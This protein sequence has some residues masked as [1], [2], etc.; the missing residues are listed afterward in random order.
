LDHVLE[1]FGVALEIIGGVWRKLEDYGE[2]WRTMEK[3]GENWRR[4]GEKWRVL[5]VE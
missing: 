1:G 2:N 5:P 3:I 4:T